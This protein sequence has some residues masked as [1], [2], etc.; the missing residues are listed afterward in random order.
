MRAQEAQSLH[1]RDRLTHVEC[2]AGSISTN[3]SGTILQL[4]HSRCDNCGRLYCNGR[5][6]CWRHETCSCC[7]SNHCTACDE[8]HIERRPLMTPCS[9]ER[10]PP[11]HPSEGV[12]ESKADDERDH[13]RGQS[14]E[15]LLVF[16]KNHLKCCSGAAT[17]Q[18]AASATRGR[19]PTA[20]ISHQAAPLSHR[21]RALHTMCP[22]V[23][24]MSPTL[25]SMERTRWRSR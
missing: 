20:S 8:M 19:A 21:L 7:G 6:G 25:R 10:A 12:A 17:P 14:C 3:C 15:D 4:H 24:R 11:L 23:H 9:S 5:Q 16:M 22:E 1:G 13:E 2:R 18:R